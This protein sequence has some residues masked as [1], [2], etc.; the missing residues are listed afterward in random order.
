MFAGSSKLRG[1]IS[2][3]WV[4]L[5]DLD[6]YSTSD[7]SRPQMKKIIETVFHPGYKQVT[8]P[9]PSGISH[10]LALVKLDSPVVFDEYVA[11]ACLHTSEQIPVEKVVLTGWGYISLVKYSFHFIS[12][13]QPQ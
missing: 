1:I 3:E 2:P 12:L 10:N 6:L 5:G 7:D 4:K 9:R 11:P 13:Q 8:F